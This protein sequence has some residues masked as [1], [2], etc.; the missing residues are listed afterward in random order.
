[1]SITTLGGLLTELDTTARRLR[2][3][4]K[5]R[6]TPVVEIDRRLA[7]LDAARR[8]IAR[9][10]EAAGPLARARH[11][12]AMAASAGSAVDHRARGQGRREPAAARCRS[13]R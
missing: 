2:V 5:A 10:L 11:R 1:M 6:A 4:F 3:E 9:Q 13:R 8:Q 7:E 12:P